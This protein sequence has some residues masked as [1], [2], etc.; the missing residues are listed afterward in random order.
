MMHDSILRDLSHAVRL[1]ARTPGF[2]FVCVLTMALAIGANTA[3]FSI[4]HGVLLR[5]LPYPDGHRLVVLGHHTDGRASIDTTTPGNFYDWQART[6]AFEAMAAFASTERVVT[7]G[8]TA[9]RLPGVLGT[10]GLFEAL[11]CEA[12][13]GRTFKAADDDP[14]AA[15]VVVLSAGLAGRSFD[16][17]RAVGRSLVING[18]PHTVVGVMPRDFSFP[19]AGA[20]YWIPARFDAAFR[21]NRDQFFL[22]GLARLRPGITIEQSRTQLDTVMDAIRRDHPQHTENVTAAAAPL[23]AYLVRDVRT[24]LLTLQGAVVVVL[25]IAC[26]NI[27]SLLLARGAAR[28]R[29]LAVRHALGASPLRLVRQLLTESLMLAL[30]GGL[31]GIALGAAV[32]RVLVGWLPED[33]PRAEAIALDPTVLAVTLGV[34]V[35]CGLIFGVWPALQQSGDATALAAREGTR[36]SARTH[37][38]RTALVVAEVALSLMLLVAAGLLV[39]SFANLLDVRPGFEA[40]RLLTFSVSLPAAVYQDPAERFGYFTRATEQLG[41]LPGVTAVARS[42]TLPVAGRGVSAWFTMLD[43]PWPPGQTPPAVPYRVVSPNY[44]AALGIPLRRG[45]ALTNEDGLDGFRAVVVSESVERRFWPGES[46]LGRRIY[47]GAPDNRLF[48]DAEIVGVAGDVKQAGLDEAT[49]EAVYIPHRLMP[50]WS[51][52]TFAVRTTV[53]PTSVAAAARGEIA[54]IDPAIPIQHLRT[55]DDIVARSLTP[56]HAS[57]SLVGLFGVVAIAL[58]LVGLFGVLAHHVSQRRMEIA[59][60]M[61]LGAPARSVKLLVVRQG[62]RQVGA[63]IALGLLGCLLVTR[64]LQELLFEVQPADPLTLAAVSAAL[65]V[66]GMGAMY[67][68]ARRAARVEPLEAIR[69][70]P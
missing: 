12:A 38:V 29:E 13:V 8:E 2:T 24:R 36:G 39:R 63:G 25:L 41:R 32:G 48:P 4:V 26:A 59:I 37:R 27:A 35:A 3:V 42:S 69:A 20:Q 66:L 22:L 50:Q 16:G 44:F 51:F 56:A 19:D 61:A 62:M 30:A 7:W 40:A 14:G 43:S 21:N 52:F 31:A 46:A 6:T 53:T 45:R 15:A 47:L 34:S 5:P 70:S 67:V 58:T 23:G 55:M 49:S 28:R 18:V 64:Y 17:G 57:M 1:L 60:R 68:P 10:G 33:L 9:E 54:R 11:G 65:L